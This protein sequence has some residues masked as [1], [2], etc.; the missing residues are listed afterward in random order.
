MTKTFAIIGDIH[1]EGIRLT[2][3]L[4][5]IKKDEIKSLLLVGDIG[6]SCLP[7]ACIPSH[8]QLNNYLESMDKI[9]KLIEKYRFDYLWVS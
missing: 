7:P 5:A 8:F 2:K 1:G 4:N 6:Q 9:F 3:I